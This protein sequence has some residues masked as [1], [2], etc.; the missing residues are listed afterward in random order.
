MNLKSGSTGGFLGRHRQN[1][2]GPHRRL[3]DLTPVDTGGGGVATYSAE[4]SQYFDR[5]LTPPS[6]NAASYY[7]ALIDGLVAA[8]VWLKLDV[9]YIFATADFSTSLINLKSSSF[10]AT[11]VT[12]SGLPTFVVNSG[13]TGCLQPGSISVLSNFN[14][15][16]AGGNYVQND[17]LVSCWKIGNVDD[18]KQLII[19][20]SNDSKIE[21]FPYHDGNTYYAVN[22]QFET[23]VTTPSPQDGFWLAQRTASDATTIY[24]NDIQ[25]GTT[26]GSSVALPN[27]I[28]AAIPNSNIYAVMAIGASL[29][30]GQRTAFYNLLTTYLTAV[31]AI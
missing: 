23:Q 1:M 11:L 26:A 16:L 17:A 13:W 5:L 4:V 12:A 6:G 27:D 2:F 28:I 9:L 15:S 29:A 10:Q 8:G 20:Q 30:E 7:A 22:G 24:Q 25:L 14:P 21:I 31:G 18:Y 19:Q 3:P